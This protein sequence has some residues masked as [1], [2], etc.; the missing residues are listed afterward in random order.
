MK[1]RKG[2]YY[3]T[4]INNTNNVYEYRAEVNSQWRNALPIFV[5]QIH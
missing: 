3:F 1:D 5:N 2:S 4:S